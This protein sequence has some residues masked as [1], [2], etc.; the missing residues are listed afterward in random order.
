MCKQFLFSPHGG[1]LAYIGATTQTFADANEDLMRAFFS[2]FN[3]NQQMP[4]GRVLDSGQN[5][6]PRHKTDLPM[7][8]RR[9]GADAF[10]RPHKF[11]H[12]PKQSKPSLF[13]LSIKRWRIAS[14][15]NFDVRIYKRDTVRVGGGAYLFDSLISRQTGTFANG[16]FTTALSDT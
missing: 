10:R 16:N 4:L 13:Y 14:S 15:G 5:D 11:K 1:A 8:F 9:S 6:G 7:F 3:G 2:T 12:G